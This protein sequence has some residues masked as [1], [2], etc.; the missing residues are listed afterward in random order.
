[1]SPAAHIRARERGLGR[2]V[3]SRGQLAK[4]LFGKLNNLVV[5]DACSDMI[6]WQV[7][8]AHTSGGG[9]HDTVGCEVAL[10]E[11]AQALRVERP[12]AAV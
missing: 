10:H 7:P 5:L 9:Q 8:A 3:R 11:L 4:V 6:G 12:A 1:M 2:L